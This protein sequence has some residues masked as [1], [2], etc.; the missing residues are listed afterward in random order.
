LGKGAELRYIAAGDST[1]VGLGASS[2]DQTYPY[3]LAQYFAK[4]KHV[5]YKNVAKSGAKTTDVINNQL[6][7]IIAFN[8]DIITISIGANDQTHLRSNGSIFKN[9]QT[10]LNTLTEKT[11]AQIYFADI[12]NFNG[13]SLLPWFYI[14][15]LEAKSKPLNKKLLELQSERTSLVSVH[16]FGWDK[17][18]NR[19]V[20]YSSDHFHP[21]DIGY[22]NWTQAFLSKIRK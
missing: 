16:D 8:P 17:F 20:T 10:V 19:S 9:Y 14:Q 1:A 7:R 11:H 18:P 4:D 2:V 22:E 13:A 15:I 5:V 21:G 6:D 3:K 12:P